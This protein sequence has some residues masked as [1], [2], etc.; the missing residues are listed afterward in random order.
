MAAIDFEKIK[1]VYFIGIKGTGVVALVEIF[2]GLKKEISGSDT[3]D[4]YYTDEILKGLGIRYYE[5]F[6]QENIKNEEPIDLVIYSTAYNAKN[7]VELQ[8]AQ[9]VGLLCLSYPEV[10]GELMKKKFGI[11]VCGTHGKTTTTAM[12]ALAMKAA[13]ADPTAIIGS[14]VNQIE[15]SVVAGDSQYLV[16]E[17][18][19][20]QNKFLHYQPIG[21]VLTSL[22][23]DHPDFFKDYE[24]YKDAFRQFIRKIPPYGFL[25]VWGE[26]VDTLEVAKEARCKI[27]VYGRFRKGGDVHKD[28]RFLTPEKIDDEA[29]LRIKE[30]FEKSG[31]NNLDFVAAPLGLELKVPGSHNIVNATAAWAVGKQLK[32]DQKKFIAALNEYTG[33]ARRFEYLGKCNDAIVIDDYAHHPEEVRATLSAARQE[34]PRKNIICVFHPHTFTRTKA[35]LDEFSQCFESCDEVIVLDIYGSARETQGEVHSKDLVEKMKQHKQKV[36]YIPTIEETYN[37]LKDRIGKD[38]VIITMGAGNVF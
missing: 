7:N 2:H 4:K 22:D 35:L 34:Y 19:E 8:H 6:S 12:L 28:R 14:R 11:A 29:I 31:K 33:A 25:V 30:E 5:N 17:A 18:D 15:S 36:E 9:E 32:L 10:I 26:S 21:V 38:D 27:I 24:E 1:K 13:G 23:F 20:Y 37:A 3:D 16:I